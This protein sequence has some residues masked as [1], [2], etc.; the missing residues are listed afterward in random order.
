[1]ERWATVFESES[2]PSFSIQ[3]KSS[4]NYR[5]F[6]FSRKFKAS[7]RRDAP[8]LPILFIFKFNCRDVNLRSCLI[9]EESKIA[10][11]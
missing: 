7:A 6:K 11:F 3:L 10:P 1:M 9:E 4:Y 5:Q 2:I 8:N